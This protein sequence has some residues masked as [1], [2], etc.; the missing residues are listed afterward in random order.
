MVSRFSEIVVD[1]VQP[2]RLAEFWCAV[3]GYRVLEE[4]EG[5]IEIVVRRG[6]PGFAVVQVRDTGIGIAPQDLE[7]VF[8]KDGRGVFLPYEEFM[9]LWRRAGGGG[10]GPEPA[11]TPPVDWAIAAGS[12]RVRSRKSAGERERRVLTARVRRSSK[13]APSRNAYGFALSSSWLKGDG[14]RVSHGTSLTAPV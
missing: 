9:R 1:C 3:L 8:E 2:R 11:A 10:S 5:A 4:H 7:K 12:S 13:G 14:S 6:K